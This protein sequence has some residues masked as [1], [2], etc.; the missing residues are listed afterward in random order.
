MG[1]GACTEHAATEAVTLGEELSNATEQLELCR[2]ACDRAKQLAD[3]R[4]RGERAQSSLA[5]LDETTDIETA[6]RES[7]DAHRR[8]ASVLPA[9]MRAENAE[10]AA[11]ETESA[12]SL[13]VSEV[14]KLLDLG[15]GEVRPAALAEAATRANEARAVAESWLPR[16]RDLHDERARL[17]SLT[18]QLARLE[19]QITADEKERA[20]YDADAPAT[21]ARAARGR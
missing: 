20:A 8:A 14:A 19:L 1:T 15:A 12:A 16:E 5:E 13:H 2:T 10:E 9:A 6:L 18:A 4:A 21:P 3:A 17:T 7:V 11:A